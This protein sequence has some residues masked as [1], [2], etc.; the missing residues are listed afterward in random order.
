MSGDPWDEFE[1]ELDNAKSGNQPVEEQDTVPRANG[2]TS[3]MISWNGEPN[4]VVQTE[5]KKEH[6]KRLIA[7]QKARKHSNNAMLDKKLL[8]AGASMMGNEAARS[9]H[10]LKYA[11]PGLAPHGAEVVAI[12]SV[13]E[14]FDVAFGPATMN[15]RREFQTKWCITAEGSP[16]VL[17][18]W[19]WSFVNDPHCKKCNSELLPAATKCRRCNMTA[20][21]HCVLE[22]TCVCFNAV[23]VV[24]APYILLP[25]LISRA[26]VY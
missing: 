16:H 14:V 10:C 21:S 7:F 24:T 17:C 1:L 18:L 23:L 3:R 20:T 15:E 9:E 8:A 4:T 13:G 5:S 19:V 2:F 11:R 6:E 12:R 26:L 22:S 25:T